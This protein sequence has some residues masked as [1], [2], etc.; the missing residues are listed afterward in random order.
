MA[1]G[2]Y[3]VSLVVLCSLQFLVVEVDHYMF[4]VPQYSGENINLLSGVQFLTS[5]QI[6]NLGQPFAAHGQSFLP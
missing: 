4:S 1:T 2:L 5:I 3:P 6:A